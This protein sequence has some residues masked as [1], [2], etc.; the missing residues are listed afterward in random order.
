MATRQ[1]TRQVLRLLNDPAKQKTMLENAAKEQE[2]FLDKKLF[3]KR[4]RKEARRRLYAILVIIGF[5]LLS[6]WGLITFI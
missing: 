1:M 3:N 6:L 2:G 5:G 4:K